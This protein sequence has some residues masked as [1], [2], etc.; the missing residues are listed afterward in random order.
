MFFFSHT[1]CFLH[2][3]IRF[4][5][6]LFKV[7]LIGDSGVGKTGLLTRFTVSIFHFGLL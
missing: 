6:R 3:D 5:D 2:A 1:K 7:L 4:S